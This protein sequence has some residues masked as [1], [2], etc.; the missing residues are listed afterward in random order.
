M[1]TLMEWLKIHILTGGLLSYKNKFIWIGSNEAD[2][3]RDLHSEVS[4]KEKDKFHTLT[5]MYG[6]EK[7]GTDESTYRA[8]T[9][10]ADIE[11][12]ILDTVEGREGR[13]I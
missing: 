4:Q 7:D 2:E 12:R 13:V 8:A 9:E 5:H 1:D 6:V 10:V 3:S 11:N